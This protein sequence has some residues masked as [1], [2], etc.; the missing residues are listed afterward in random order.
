MRNVIPE[1][2]VTPMTTN[3]AVG[4]SVIEKLIPVNSTLMMNNVYNV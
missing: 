1:V 3:A 2:N 4:Y